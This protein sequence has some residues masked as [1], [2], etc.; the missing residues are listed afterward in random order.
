LGRALPLVARLW[1]ALEGS[2]IPY[3]H[4][5]SNAALDRSLAGLNDLDLLVGRAA[6]RRFTEVLSEVGL[7]RA[8]RPGRA[9]PGIESFYGFDAELDRWVH[10]HAHYQL[11]LG[12]DRTKNYRLPIEEAYIASAPPS[13]GLRVPAPE[14]EFVVFVIRMVLKYCTWDEIVWRAARGGRAGP[15]S[16]ECR[17]LEFLRE[18]I[19][20]E[21]VSAVLAEHLPAVDPGLF[22]ACVAAVADEVPTAER[23]RTGRRL[24]IALG[25]YARR[26]RP[27]DR[28]LRIG[29]RAAIAAGRRLRRPPRNRLVGGG[30]M[31]A[32]MGGDGAGKSTAL[33]ALEAWLGQEFEVRLVHLG[34]PRWSATTTTVRGGLKVAVAAVNALQR[35]TSAASIDRLGAVVSDYRPLLWLL[36]TARD[37]QRAYRRARR[38]ATNG[39]IVLCDR[40]PHPRLSSM[41]VPLIAARAGERVDDALVKAMIGLEERYHRS[42]APPELLVVLRVDPE[43]AVARKSDESPDSVLRR[44]AEIWNIDWRAAGAHVIDASQS[45]EAVARELEQLVWSAIS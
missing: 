15:S 9:M 7:V 2:G 22:S 1:R 19:D 34:K 13:E 4:W 31:V 44:G 27:V 43:V 17:E 20:S 37:R 33:A 18:R 16:S 42:I 38:G 41:E 35:H 24:E 39:A 11:V 26:S 23:V 40:Y 45:P 14:F 3:C 5:K 21:G 8:Y 29:R 30:A 6:V 12:D 32:I 28:A 25:P 36:C 10:V